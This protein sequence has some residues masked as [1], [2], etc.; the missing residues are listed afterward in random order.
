[1]A[2]VAQES[3]LLFI[4]ILLFTMI[5]YSFFFN[6]LVS[7]FCGVY[8]SLASDIQG[9]ARLG[10]GQIILETLKTVR[11]AR[12]KRFMSS[13]ALDRRVDFGEGD[14]GLAG[15]RIK[16][17]EPALLHAVSK[18]EI[19]RFGGQTD[20]SLPW[21]EKD[22]GDANEMERMIRG[23]KIQRTLKSLLGKK[24]INKSG[25]DDTRQ[26]ATIAAA[27]AALSTSDSATSAGA[28]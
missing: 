3:P 1:M 12:W 24:G 25:G 21:P 27:T 10:R 17:W 22:A 28:L 4:V 8:M 6:L 11:M 13:L 15:G 19:I 7:Q 18:D 2:V 20:P 9:H 5:V 26:V 14:I 16:A 23:T